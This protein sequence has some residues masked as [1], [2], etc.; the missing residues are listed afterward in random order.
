[1]KSYCGT[2]EYILDWFHLAQKFQQVTNAL[3]EA[4]TAS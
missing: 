4:F 1:M 3:G 2:L